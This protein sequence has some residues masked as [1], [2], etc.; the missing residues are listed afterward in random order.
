MCVCVC[1]LCVTREELFVE[2]RGGLQGIVIHQVCVLET[3]L[4]SSLNH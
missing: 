4:S 3:K 1:V 2:V